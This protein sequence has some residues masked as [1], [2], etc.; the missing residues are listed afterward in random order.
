MIRLNSHA[1]VRHNI[2]ES[3]VCSPIS[4]VAVVVKDG[5]IF[6]DPLTHDW[7]I[8]SEIIRMISD[9]V[10]MPIDIVESD[11]LS[12]CA[13]LENVG[14][15]EIRGKDVSV[16]VENI[17]GKKSNSFAQFSHLDFYLKHGLISD[18]HIDLTNK[19]NERC[20]HCYIPYG[21]N[22]M[23]DT[24]LAINVLHEFR[25]MEGLT[26]ML[27]GGECLLHQDFEIIA[28]EARELDLN[29]VI[30]SNL[31]FC[32]DKKIE[33]IKKVK[34]QFVNVSLYSMDE[35]VHDG[36]TRVKGSWLRTTEAIKR[37]RDLGVEIRLATPIMKNNKD[38]ISQIESFASE[39]GAK[40][41][42][43][44]DI[45]GR[46]NQDDS[47]RL[48]ALRANEL[49][50]VMRAHKKELCYQGRDVKTLTRE[51]RVCEIGDFNININANGEYYPC[52]GF[53]GMIVGNANYSTLRE[54]WYGEKMNEL[55]RMKYADFGEC[56]SCENKAWCKVCAM[57]NFN[58]TGDIFRHAN[59]RCD[60]ARLHRLMQ[61]EK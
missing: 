60:L 51:S 43:D 49:E 9:K 7:Q 27:S 11:F 2:D 18:L 31:L 4:E 34:P 44:C 53:Q 1:F 19:C 17:E 23:M 57:R 33:I 8:I 25:A 54:V 15:V 41:S 29:I 37:L 52:D 22:K 36:I 12:V 42:F 14:L 13:T 61:E 48:C 35:A 45:I 20:V 28:Q 47:N 26:V 39:I 21:G 56:A 6:L 40:T 10:C 5:C 55:R 59:F 46:M 50:S 24:S 58:E 32:D 38:S 30:M 3:L 16:T